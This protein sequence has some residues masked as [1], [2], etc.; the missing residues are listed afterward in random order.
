LK[1]DDSLDAFGVHGVGG[2]LGAVLTGV[3]CYKWTYVEPA[4]GNNGL[5][6]SEWTDYAQVWIQFKAAALSAVLAL[7]VSLILVKLIDLVLGFIATD[8]EEIEG[9]D[10]T[11]HGETGFDFGYG[12]ST[13]PV[14]DPAVPRA[15]IVPPN[16]VG[17]FKLIVEGTGNGDLI[18]AWSEL[19]KPSDNP[20]PEFKAIYP[21][22]TTVQGNRFQFR[23]GDQ[24]LMKD[25]LQKLFEKVLKR[26]L[27][28][29][30]EA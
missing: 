13:A 2:F 6:A 18:H 26:P 1:Y 7:V 25:N 19:C 16:G 22:V 12:F 30:V 17:R 28:V 20:A 8:E 10:R 29:K 11:E 27:K 15:A 21:F 5:A 4:V 24:Q 9:L 3:F 23:G 14:T